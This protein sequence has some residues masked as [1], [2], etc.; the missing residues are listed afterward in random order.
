MGETSSPAL[1]CWYDIGPSV[2][3]CSVEISD[4]SSAMIIRGTVINLAG[5]LSML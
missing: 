3:E 5:Y 2:G 4:S 1:G